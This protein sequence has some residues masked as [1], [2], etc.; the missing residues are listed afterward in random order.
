MII[1]LF[2]YLNMLVSFS[3]IFSKEAG[4]SGYERINR[5][6]S[7]LPEG[8][9]GAGD[10]VLLGKKEPDPVGCVIQEEGT[11]QSLGL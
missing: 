9:L 2:Q 6:F 5:G 7:W 1:F 3:V 11:Y 8:E 4:V 10:G